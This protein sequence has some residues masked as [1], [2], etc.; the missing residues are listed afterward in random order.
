[1]NSPT[2]A[3]QPAISSSPKTVEMDGFPATGRSPDHI[4]MSR[5][6]NVTVFPLPP[7]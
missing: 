6:V 2:V 7:V 1:M 4:I 5:G 3:D